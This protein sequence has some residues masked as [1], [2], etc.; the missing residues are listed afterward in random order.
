MLVNTAFTKRE[1]V[2]IPNDE[3]ADY[4]ARSYR[5]RGPVDIGNNIA[6]A[7]ST[8]WTIMYEQGQRRFYISS[9]GGLT[10]NLTTHE[11][12]HKVTQ[13]TFS[14]D[15]NLNVIWAYAYD[16]VN[17]GKSQV[18]VGE[19]I[20][21]QAPSQITTIENADAPTMLLDYPANLGVDKRPPSVL[22]FYNK[23]GTSTICVRQDDDR[24]TTERTSVDV[25]SSE[26]V[27]KSFRTDGLRIGITTQRQIGFTTYKTL[28]TAN[29][30][31]LLDVHGNPLW[32]THNRPF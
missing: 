15:K 29:G 30:D 22:L 2:V 4:S 27:I 1:G 25:L 21:Q 18:Y 14:F 28:L 32:V 20:N 19:L 23:L 13:V 16:N 12:H 8:V 26:K 17:T 6:G 10:Y 24:Y 11:S 5:T 31:I 7:D 3:N 9:D